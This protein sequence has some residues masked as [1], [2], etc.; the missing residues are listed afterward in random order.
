M[1][2]RSSLPR[3]VVVALDNAEE[4]VRSFVDEQRIKFEGM[5]ERW[6]RGDRSIEIS[7]WLDH[8]DDLADRIG[9][10]YGRAG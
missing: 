3:E 9:Y 8:L 2:V 7:D 10:C 1:P 6:H 4:T 5:S